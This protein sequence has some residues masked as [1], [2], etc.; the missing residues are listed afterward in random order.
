M[1][2]LLGCERILMLCLVL[3]CFSPFSRE[4]NRQTDRQRDGEKCSAAVLHAD[5]Q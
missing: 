2:E 3:L 4:C 5:I 1:M